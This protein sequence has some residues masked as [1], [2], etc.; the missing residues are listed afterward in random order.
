MGATIFSGAAVK[1]LK[2]ILKIPA[3]TSG[4]LS[5]QPAATTTDHTLTMPSANASGALTNDGAG[6]LS[7]TP[8]ASGGGGSGIEVVEIAAN[9]AKAGAE[10]LVGN[11]NVLVEPFVSTDTLTLNLFKAYGHVADTTTIYLDHNKTDVDLLEATTGW[12]NS[13][14]TW[15]LTQNNTAGQFVQG[16]YGMKAAAT[17][18]G[19]GSIVKTFTAFSLVDRRLRLVAHLDTVT[20]LTRL[21]VKLE[22]SGSNDVTYY[23]PVAGLSV[24]LNYLEVNLDSTA[25]ASTGTFVRGGVTKI[26]LG[27]VTGASQALNITWDYLRSVPSTKFM[28]SLTAGLSIPIYD[29]TN[30]E[31]LTLSS[32]NA[33]VA[34]KFTLASA[35]SNDYAIATAT[36]KYQTGTVA[37][38]EGGFN[39][40]L[41]GAALSTA[42]FIKRQTLPAVVSG[43]T[44]KVTGTWRGDSFPVT[45]FDV[46]TS[47]IAVDGDYSARFKNGD[48]IVLFKYEPSYPWSLT[49]SNSTLG[50]NFKIL[51]LALD[52]SYK[53]VGGVLRTGI[54]TVESIDTGGDTANWYI[55]RLSLFLKYFV[56]NL[57][58]SESYS[59]LT[60]TAFFPNSFKVTKFFDDFN[61]PD[62]VPGNN[63][64]GFSSNG[65]S[66]TIV[67]NQ[68]RVYGAGTSNTSYSWVYRNLENYAISLMPIELTFID[69]ESVSGGSSTAYTEFGM[70]AV[71]TLG[72]IYNGNA[73]LGLHWEMANATATPV[74]LIGNSATGITGASATIN[75][76]VANFV[77]IQFFTGKVNLKVWPTTSQEPA[78]WTGS[79]T[80]ATPTLPGNYLV[81]AG[82][83]GNGGGGYAWTR[84]V[85]NVDLHTIDGGYTIQGEVSGVTGGKVAIDAVLT[86]Q[87]TTNDKPTVRKFGAILQ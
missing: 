79:W 87:D 58:A 4:T 57:N 22:S 75:T 80:F 66:E 85:D 18:N 48:K 81:I 63:W 25:D 5:I 14:G 84:Y 45:Y 61:R 55:T 31:V 34:G 26:Y 7:W 28:T 50:G 74:L 76:T 1:L 8:A 51:T 30:M 78:N 21:T 68:F 10:Y 73:G 46:P 43:N 44:L 71:T 49:Y 60:P 12:G 59:T 65:E 23:F 27:A 42:H 35:L 24:G 20:N 82:V 52:S 29:G 33:S 83:G 64:T 67:S 37:G 62:G 6:A 3:A 15:T 39:T 9:V 19:A 2:S 54:G 72:S 16:T 38:Q 77:K 56:G 41:T 47:S 32:E 69:S 86:R 53:S 17:L 70:A 40:G 13:V 36:A 11:G